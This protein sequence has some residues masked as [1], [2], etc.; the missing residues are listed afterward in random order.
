MT[1]TISGGG[2]DHKTLGYIYIYTYLYMESPLFHIILPPHRHIKLGQSSPG[3][4]VPAVRRHVASYHWDALCR[5]PGQGGA[6]HLSVIP[7]ATRPD[8]VGLRSLASPTKMVGFYMSLPTKH[9]GFQLPN[10]QQ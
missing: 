10:G 6:E 4:L 2:V 5:S 7:T 1:I 8:I 9:G 3:P